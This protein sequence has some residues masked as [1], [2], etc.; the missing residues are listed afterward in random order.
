MSQE[1]EPFLAKP[2]ISLIHSMLQSRG[3]KSQPPP[4]TEVY[5]GENLVLG[6]RARL[7]YKALSM[8]IVESGFDENG[9]LKPVIDF[10]I[11]SQL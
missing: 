8:R 7:V 10:L 11:K 9:L 5:S 2:F 3:V 4:T 1:T 6:I